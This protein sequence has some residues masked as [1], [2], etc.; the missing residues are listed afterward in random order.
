MMVQEYLQSDKQQL[1]ILSQEYSTD[2]VSLQS[3]MLENQNVL[4]CLMFRLAIIQILLFDHL[5]I[6]QAARLQSNSNGILMS[7]QEEVSLTNTTF[8][9]MELKLILCLLL[10]LPTQ[11]VLDLHQDNHMSLPSNPLQTSVEVKLAIIQNS[12]QSMFLQHLFS[13]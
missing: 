8:G 10:Y 12:G 6:F 4:Q 7:T 9:W 11:E 3:T 13:L 2:S 5:S 1:I